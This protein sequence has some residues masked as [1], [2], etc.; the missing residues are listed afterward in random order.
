MHELFF[1][2]LFSFRSC[3]K[4]FLILPLSPSSTLA[5]SAKLSTILKISISLL[6]LSLQLLTQ[7]CFLF[8]H[9]H[10]KF[11][12]IVGYFFPRSSGVRAFSTC[13]SNSVR[14]LR[15]RT[16]ASGIWISSPL[17]TTWR[18]FWVMALF[19]YMLLL[20]VEAG[21]RLGED[22]EEDGDTRSI[23]L[24]TQGDAAFRRSLDLHSSGTSVPQSSSKKKKKAEAQATHP[25]PSQSS[26]NPHP[27]LCLVL[28]PEP[29]L[30][31]SACTFVV[32]VATIAKFLT[33]WYIANVVPLSASL[34]ISSR[35]RLEPQQPPLDH[36]RHINFIIQCRRHFVFLHGHGG[37]R[38]PTRVLPWLLRRPN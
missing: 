19:Q 20:T 2:H 16:V 7:V 22:E 1:L 17:T 27:N 9:D 11:L 12:H 29:Q 14:H 34:L 24:E 13:P 6:T 21:F 28:L 32:K 38:K 3:L 35:R 25:G 37:F 26:P 15:R 30:P 4:V 8:C 33:S 36:A 10:I 31:I 23:V 5:S 18:A